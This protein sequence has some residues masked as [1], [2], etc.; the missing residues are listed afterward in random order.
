MGCRPQPLEDRTHPRWFVG[1]VR[2]A[3][4]AGIVPAAG[5]NDGGGS[6]R[7]PAACNGLVGPKTSRGISP[8]GPQTG[9]LPVQL[10]E[11]D[12]QEVTGQGGVVLVRAMLFR[13]MAQ[14]QAAVDRSAQRRAV[15]LACELVESA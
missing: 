3:V 1:W 12:R 13:L 7:I 9:D 10:G 6:V 15:H 14:P 11:R 2:A 4:A 8:Y 5:A